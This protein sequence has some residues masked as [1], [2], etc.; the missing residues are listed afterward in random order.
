MDLINLEWDSY[1]FGFKVCK[2]NNE[3]IGSEKELSEVL[4]KAKHNLYSLCYLMVPDKNHLL[5]EAAISNNG[6]L[7]D[8]KVT[9]S[10]NK[11]TNI[12]T[13]ELINV[14]NYNN[15]ININELYNLAIQSSHQSRFRIDKNFK[16]NICDD[17]Y[18]IWMDESISGN[19]AKK[20]FI[21]TDNNSAKGFITLDIVN[22]IGKIILIGVDSDMRG[23]D[24]GRKLIFKSF[25]YFNERGIFIVEVDTQ[26]RN[27][28]ACIFYKKCGFEISKIL[29]IYHF[30][31]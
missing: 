22:N 23:K 6:L 14:I 27:T 28:G 2:I 7:V 13:L 1:F 8:E 17:M 21:Y 29:N 5:N 31:L 30:W 11:T 10:I 12:D 24:I 19:M 9:F 18:K 15:K 25:R 3:F 26:K 20:V 4:Q 16:S